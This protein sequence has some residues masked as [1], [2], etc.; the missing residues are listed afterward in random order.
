[1]REPPTVRGEGRGHRGDTLV[2]RRGECRWGGT[3]DT[4][5]EGGGRGITGGKAQ[6]NRCEVFKLLSVLLKRL[7]GGL[8]DGK[9]STGRQVQ[10]RLGITH[11]QWEDTGEWGVEVSV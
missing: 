8:V 11:Y 4:M 2:G 3:G 1:M 9:V 10:W 5:V 7:R 6:V